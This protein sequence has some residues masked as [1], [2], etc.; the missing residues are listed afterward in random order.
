MRQL[1]TLLAVLSLAGC[2]CDLKKES[3]TKVPLTL[4]EAKKL[5]G[6]ISIERKT[7][8][9]G[10]GGGCGHSA[11]CVVLLPIIVFDAMFPETWDEVVVRKGD[12]VRLLASYDKS[13]DLIHAQHLVDGE[14]RETRFVELRKLGKKVYVDSAR[15]VP[16]ADGGTERVLL[17]LSA[18]H[19]FV[20]DMRKLLGRT[21][22]PKER[23]EIIAEA[24][25]QLEQEGRD[26]ALERL[27]ASDEPDRARGAAVTALCQQDGA[28]PLLTETKKTGGPWVKLA[29]VEC[30][31]YG[32]PEREAAQLEL[33]TALCAPDAPVD[34][35][36]AAERSFVEEARAAG[37]HERALAAW[38]Q[39]PA[40]ANRAMVGLFLEAKPAPA[41]LIAM[42]DSPVRKL[43]S[44]HLDPGELDQRI[45]MVRLIELDEHGTSLML[46]KLEE[47]GGPLEPTLLASL[48]KRFV[49]KKGFFEGGERPTLLKIF[50]ASRKATEPTWA[51]GAR[52]WFETAASSEKDAERRAMYEALR[53]LLGDRARLSEATRGLKSPVPASE[54]PSLDAEVTAWALR[55]SG[56]TQAELEGAATQQ[57]GLTKCS[58]APGQ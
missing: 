51:R 45:A 17:P 18:Q 20:G 16:Q 46:L 57:K 49:E 31:T 34:V 42:V 11:V 40:G 10:G 27:R 52:S 26:F 21:K 53:V 13:G 23:G 19:D 39:C 43:A 50:A 33:L 14:I 1:A 15:L 32:T 55:A 41:D 54:R 36:D 22:D 58:G 9:S 7:R 24:A 25:R 48:A 47:W 56:C 4:A 29:L 30:A 35:L 2:C 44:D 38:Q 12:E 6:E 5:D 37:L 8:H 3:Y 28:G